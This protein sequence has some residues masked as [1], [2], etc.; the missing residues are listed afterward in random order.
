LKMADAGRFEQIPV[1]CGEDRL[2]RHPSVPGRA[3]SL[4]VV[5]PNLTIKTEIADAVDITRPDS[6]YRR[7]GVS[8]RVP[9][10]DLGS[11]RAAELPMSE[12]ACGWAARARARLAGS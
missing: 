1:G 3:R 12:V 10:T 5:A 9:I 7:T 8:R 6:F 11:S 4:L 2:D